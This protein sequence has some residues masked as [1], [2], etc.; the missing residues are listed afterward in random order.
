MHTFQKTLNENRNEAWN[1]L[2]E[3]YIKI[4]KK[5]DDLLCF[6]FAQLSNTIPHSKVKFGERW[7]KGVASKDKIYMEI[8][9]PFNT[10]NLF[11]VFLSIEDDKYKYQVKEDDIA[12]LKKNDKLYI[13]IHIPNTNSLIFDFINLSD[14]T[15]DKLS[16]K[17]MK[18]I[19]SLNKD[20]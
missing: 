12:I 10:T 18:M 8:N 4:R 6:L 13:S 2:E 5:E 9:Y 15:L 11:T 16:N 14:L 17:I 7:D 3:A 19:K 1:I 20:Y